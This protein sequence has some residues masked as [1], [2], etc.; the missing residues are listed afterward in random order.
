[1]ANPNPKSKKQKSISHKLPKLPFKCR[2]CGE[3]NAVTILTGKVIP[4]VDGFLLDDENVLPGRTR[5]DVDVLLEENY[6]LRLVLEDMREEQGK[7]ELKRQ[8]LVAHFESLD[9]FRE[10]KLKEV[11]RNVRGNIS[12]ASRQLHV[13]TNTIYNWIREHHL[14][15]FLAGV[16]HGDN[17]RDR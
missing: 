16:R 7:H 8:D 1:M 12:E 13:S 9:D 2:H 11:L 3:T 17:G 15:P 5:S 14:E 10:I 6:K 4:G